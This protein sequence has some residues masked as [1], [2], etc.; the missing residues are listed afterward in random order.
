VTAGP[1]LPPDIAAKLEVLDMLGSAYDGE[2]AAAGRRAN[3]MVKDAGL[4][5]AEVITPTAPKP[6]QP[7]R[8]SRRWHRPT[9]PSDTAALCL[10]WPEVLD[11]WETD[12]CR[13]I[14]AQRQISAK[15]AAVLAKI[16]GK[17]EAF[18]RVAGE[19]A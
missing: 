3:A 15:Q 8:P 19:C 1:H 2:I 12:F 9:S 7:H 16:I 14:A 11:D 5:W 17:V 10:Q 18:A 13:S 4:T 6:E